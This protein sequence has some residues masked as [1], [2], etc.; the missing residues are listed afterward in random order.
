M[1]VQGMKDYLQ[2][3]YLGLQSLSDYYIESCFRDALN[4][5]S[6]IYFELLF[7]SEIVKEYNIYAIENLKMDIDLLEG[8]FN[9]ISLTH[10]GF[11]ECLVPLKTLLNVFIQKKFDIFLDKN[12]NIETFFDIK[13]VKIVK[14]LLKY[15]NLKKSS[16]M[17]GR[18]TESE[19]TAMIRKIKEVHNINIK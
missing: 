10:L 15:K 8:F 4:F 9:D 18:I 11:N 2:F 3:V 17:K 6:K 13:L 19:I 12:K 7:N 16:D 5:I 14:F 1:Y